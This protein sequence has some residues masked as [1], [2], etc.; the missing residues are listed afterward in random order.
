MPRKKMGNSI[1]FGRVDFRDVTIRQEGS[2]WRVGWNL[3]FYTHNAAEAMALMAQLVAVESAAHGEYQ[4][5]VSI[6]RD[7]NVQAAL[8]KTSQAADRG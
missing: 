1:D 3:A 6:T 8:D 7:P 4:A 2:Q 5:A